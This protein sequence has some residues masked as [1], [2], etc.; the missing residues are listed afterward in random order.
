MATALAGPADASGFSNRFRIHPL[1]RRESVKENPESVMH[2]G[3]VGF[4]RLAGPGDVWLRDLQSTNLPG[5][6]ISQT[7]EGVFTWTCSGW[8]PCVIVDV[9]EQVHVD[10]FR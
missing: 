9:G 3:V 1:L 6:G 2:V 5:G 4:R 7:A 10:D 8:C